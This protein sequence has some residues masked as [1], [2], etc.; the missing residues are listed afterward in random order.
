MFWSS[1]RHGDGN[2]EAAREAE[3]S[4]GRNERCGGRAGERVLRPAEPGPRPAPLRPQRGEPVPPLLQGRFGEAERHAW[5]VFPFAV[6]GLTCG[7]GVRGGGWAG[8][9]GGRLSR[10]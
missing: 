4:L 1:I 5:R 10:L 2:A 7:G 3:R 9:R 8:G 6:V